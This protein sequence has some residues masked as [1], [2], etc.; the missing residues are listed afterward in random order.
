MYCR[1]KSIDA[2]YHP[3]AHAQGSPG[4]TDTQRKS[5]ELTWRAGDVSPLV[6]CQSRRLSDAQNGET[7]SARCTDERNLCANTR[8]ADR[9]SP[10]DYLGG[11]RMLKPNSSHGKLPASA[12][13]KSLSGSRGSPVSPGIAQRSTVTTI[14][15]A[16]AKGGIELLEQEGPWQRGVAE[17][18]VPCVPFPIPVWAMLVCPPCPPTIT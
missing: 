2:R 3:R 15:G 5:A 6:G 9:K 7:R 17:S 18:R 1:V 16:G 12:S 13:R 4:R 10:A 14:L 8:D 11:R